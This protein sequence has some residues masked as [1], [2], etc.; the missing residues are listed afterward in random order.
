MSKAY[1]TSDWHLG[2]R[3][4]I[5]Y[6]PEFSSIQEHDQTL[7]A[8][9][10]TLVTKRDIVYFL[11]DIAF[12]EEAIEQLKELNHCRKILVMGNHD[13]KHASKFL[14]VFDDLVGLKAYRSFWL[15]HCPIHPQEMR[16]RVGNIHGHL[17]RSILNDPD[18]KYF[19]VSPEKH[20]YM[21]VDLTTIQEH[22]KNKE[23]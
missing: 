13:Y 16:E 6:R 8:N 7:I 14:G 4:I 15:S 22:F 23:H 20:N 12:T 2:H 18:G 11:G 21:P 3:N 10:N 1:F 9:F 19:D 17:H 5:K